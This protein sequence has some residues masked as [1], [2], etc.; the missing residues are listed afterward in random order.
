MQLSPLDGIQTFGS[1][2]LEDL[3]YGALE[4]GQRV[5]G[6]PR[7]KHRQFVRFYKQK[8]NYPKVIDS[9]IN[10]VTGEEVNQKY[11]INEVEK[12]FVHVITPGDKNETNDLAQDYHKRQYFLQYKAFREGKGVVLGTNLDDVDFL[13][14][15]IATELRILGVQTLEMF[16]DSSDHLC[17]L[18]P[19]GWELREHA[20]AICKMNTDNKSLDQVNV[21]KGEL[22]TSKQMIQEM[23]KQMEEMKGMLLNAQGDPIDLDKSKKRK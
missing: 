11:A 18:I 15:N 14:G 9:R 6:N 7:G 22:E 17:N 4:Q 20:R 10:Q 21:L 1:P 12:E 13:S 16:A 2:T 5:G 8:V 3:D 19:S 23:Q